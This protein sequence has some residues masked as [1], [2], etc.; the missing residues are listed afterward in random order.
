MPPRK[1]PAAPPPPDPQADMVIDPFLRDADLL[2]E[3]QAATAQ[4]E[5]SRPVPQNR[6]HAEHSRGSLQAKGKGKAVDQDMGGY[7]EAGV[8]DGGMAGMDQDVWMGKKISDPIKS[9]EVRRVILT[10]SNVAS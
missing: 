10:D 9:V 6:N 4:H 2:A 8:G 5:S 1:N 3:L 7:G